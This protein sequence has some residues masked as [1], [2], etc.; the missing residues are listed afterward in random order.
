MS[1]FPCKIIEAD[2]DADI[3]TLQMEGDYTVSAGQKYLC[4]AAAASAEPVAAPKGWRLVPV[5]PTKEMLLAGETDEYDTAIWWDLMLAAAPAA[6]VTVQPDL[7][8]QT[9]DDVKAGIP[10][11]DAEIEA[12]RTEVEA[13]QAALAQ[14]DRDAVD[15][16]RE[17]ME[18]HSTGAPEYIVC[19]EL[20]RIAESAQLVDRSTEMQRNLVDETPNL[21]SQQQ[22]VSGAD[23]VMTQWWLAALDKY[24]NPTLTDGAH[25][26]RDG[27]DRAAYLIEAMS[28]SPGERYAVAKVELTAPRPSGSGVNHDAIAQINRAALAQQD[29]MLDSRIAADMAAIVETLD[30]GEWAEHIA[31]ADLGQRLERHITQLVG[32]QQDASKVDAAL[33]EMVHAMFRSANSIPVTRITIDRKQYE[34][35]IDAARKEPDQWL[36]QSRP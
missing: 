35:A 7:T 34:A 32:K 23:G 18:L 8:Q 19:A 3:V 20:V 16:A 13:L 33:A 28:L 11:R 25:S 4:D 5:S 10:A 36:N 17:G 26:D 6:P 21:Q 30:E 14:P 31:K 1:S 15:L 22:P 27:A 2:L 29:A 24:G 9:L 12:L